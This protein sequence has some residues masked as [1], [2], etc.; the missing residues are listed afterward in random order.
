MNGLVLSGGGSKGSFQVGV[1][2]Y[3]AGNNHIKGGFRVISG[4]SVGSIN[5]GALSM[6]APERFNNAV[7]NLE[8][9]WKKRVN[10]T[11]SIW[12]KRWPL[13]LPALWKPS[14]GKADGLKKILKQELDPEAIR[15]S[16]VRLRIPAVDL[17]T[18]K[19]EY[20]TEK[21][22]DLIKVILASAS[23]PAMFEPTQM[24]DGWYSDGG[25]REVTPLSPVIQAG[26]RYILI[27]SAEPLDGLKAV[28][29]KSLSNT[30]KIGSRMV[31]VI[32]NEIIL[33]DI[34][35]CQS[36][37]NKL[38]KKENEVL[39]K[40]YVSIKIVYPEKPLHNSLDF[41]KKIMSK[42]IELG[43]ERARELIGQ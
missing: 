42:Q 4:S 14:I 36:I 39:D 5:A 33:N 18:G 25:L 37:N 6:Y 26:A 1:L 31:D 16:G 21:S 35:V 15:A 24:E 12:K 30:L 40:K 10:G 29:K 41:N 13:G 23:Y 43:Y 17:L 7:E 2:K 38:R 9:L 28:E 20:F 19:L 27:I 22:E 3:I 11:S 34:K 32:M 8:A